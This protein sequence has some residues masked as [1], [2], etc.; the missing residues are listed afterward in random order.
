MVTVHLE[1]FIEFRGD[2][3]ERTQRRGRRCLF[4]EKLIWVKRWWGVWAFWVFLLHA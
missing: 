4:C 1:I 2:C 3:S